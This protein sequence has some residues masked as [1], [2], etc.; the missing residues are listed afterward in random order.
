[1]IEIFSHKFIKKI[2]LTAH[3]FE[4]WTAYRSCLDNNDNKAD[5]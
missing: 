5:F 4:V 3:I 2:T 1:M